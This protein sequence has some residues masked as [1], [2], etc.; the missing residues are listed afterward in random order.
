MHQLKVNLQE[1]IIA[2]YRQGW[3]KRR[4]AR[5]LSVDRSAVRRYVASAE[6][7]PPTDPRTGSA[8]P[9]TP[10]PTIDPRTESE[11]EDSKP[12]TNPRTGSER[13]SGIGP[14]SLCEPWKE[15]IT[16]ALAAGLS[17]QRIHQDL[18]ER[19]FDGSY[20]SVWRYVRRLERVLEL[21]FRRMEVEP[22]AE[23]QV[24]FG[25]GAWVLE[26][27]KR[28]RPHLFRG[29][30]SHS[31]KGYSEA[32]WRQDTETFIR[33]LENN[34]R[35]IGG[36]PRRVIVD[37]LR[38]AVSRADWFDPELNPKVEE[39]CRHYGTILLPTK[40][41]MPRHKGKIESGINYGQENALRGRTFESLAAQNLHL[42][43]WEA[44]VADTRIHGTTKQQV[45]RI[46]MEVEKPRLL[47]LPSSLFPVFEEGQRS[48]HRDGHIE[49]ARAY[50]SVPPEY[51][52]RRVWVRWESRLVRI[53]NQR[54]E[55]IAL[56]TRREPGKFATDPIHIHDH[57]RAIIERGADWLLD[58]ARL[59]GKYSGTW[60]EQMFA[61]R[62]PQ[63]IRALHGLLALAEKHPVAE[64]ERVCQQAIAYGAWR[65]R[66][67]RQ[68]LERAPQQQLSFLETHP[69][70][71][72]LEAY[73]QIV[74]VCF[75]RPSTLKPESNDES[76]QP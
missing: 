51:V 4:I 74:P 42:S 23:L 54:W 35:S 50:Y 30:L 63:A 71:R 25:Q 1:T 7:K 34:F 56:H 49:L 28:R 66:D 32:V 72:D 2:L 10:N 21:P 9:Q 27:G 76:I 61:Q 60:A 24:D 22:G 46:F 39:F 47:P 58:R 13:V 36:V 19:D 73:D 64:L 16:A 40:P 37:N 53:Y 55:Q 29:V 67:L 57:K 43:E 6:A 59:I 65:L 69:L 18:V 12:P 52:G 75:D 11:P 26:E 20:D 33:C 3:S 31:R 8:A 41:A 17:I 44:K 15:Q 38:A 14:E 62:G 70:I 68:L 45:G 48:V 5:E